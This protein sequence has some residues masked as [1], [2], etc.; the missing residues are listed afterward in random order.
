MRLGSLLVAHED[1]D[2]VAARELDNARDHLHGNKQGFFF[3]ALPILPT[4][5]AL[6]STAANISN[7]ITKQKRLARDLDSL[8]ALC[9]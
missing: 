9:P 8:T 3:K 4:G 1:L 7:T 2:E 6:I 5:K